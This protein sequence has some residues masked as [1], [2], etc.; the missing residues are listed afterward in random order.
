[1]P[2]YG[3]KTLQNAYAAV[4]QSVFEF[5]HSFAQVFLRIF[6]VVSQLAFRHFF[7]TGACGLIPIY[8]TSINPG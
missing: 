4:L 5:S 6:I 7:Q 1:M 3:K 2:T 8:T